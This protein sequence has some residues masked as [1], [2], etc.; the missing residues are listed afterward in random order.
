MPVKKAD[1]AP[2][3]PNPSSV[4]VRRQPLVRENLAL[5]PDSRETFEE[6]QA[7]LEG[8]RIKYS[9]MHAHQEM[10]AL[11]LA[12]G[13]S[14][15][16]AATRA[17][18]S[19]RQV[20]KYYTEADF[21]ARIEELRTVMFSKVRGRV[22]KEL[23]KRT[24]PGKID[25]IELLDLLRVF[26]RVAGPLGGKAGIQISGDVNV[27][28]NY[29]NIIQALLTPQPEPEGPDFPIY[30]VEGVTIPSGDSPE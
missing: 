8:K 21:R 29:D 20:R 27:S 30:T 10:A 23:E 12:A 9:G 11:V 28:N 6:R 24:E 4:D 26:D 7:R 5:V 16:M 17:G 22:I 13:G 2:L 18:I 15:K 3:P 1:L 14:F 25:N 19:M